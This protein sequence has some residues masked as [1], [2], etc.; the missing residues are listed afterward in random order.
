MENKNKLFL[1]VILVLSFI[2]LLTSIYLVK[3]HYSTAEGSFC[4][5]NDKISCSLVNSSVFSELFNVPVALFGVFWFLVLIYFSFKALKEKKDDSL[6]SAILAWSIA[7]ILFVV[8]MIIG[9]IFLKALCPFCTV[10]HVI[11]LVVLILAVLLY[12]NSKKTPFKSLLKEFKSLIIFM[13]I[14]NLAIII[15]FN[16]P[17]SEKENYDLLAQCITD[18][19]VNMYGSFR[20]GV[21]AKT[22]AMFDDSFQYINEIECHPQGENPQTELCVEKQIDGTPTWIL[23]PEGEEVK[24]YQGFLSIDELKEFSGCGI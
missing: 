24:R 10:V 20:C 12:R 8:Y 11:V 2:G 14:I 23:E 7:G 19:G 18:K 5:V 6:I 4:D 3:D 13:V 15:V 17:S 21:C 9:E 1:K 22:R 16:L